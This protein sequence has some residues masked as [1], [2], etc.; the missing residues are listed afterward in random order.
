[1]GCNFAEFSNSVAGLL[2]CEGAPSQPVPGLCSSSSKERQAGSSAEA[3]LCEPSYLLAHCCPVSMSM[4]GNEKLA[5]LLSQHDIAYDDRLSVCKA[6]A[7]VSANAQNASRIAASSELTHSM[8][9][10]L[11][12]ADR[13][14][15]IDTRH[16]AQVCLAITRC[17]AAG[18]DEASLAFSKAPGLVEGLCRLQRDSEPFVRVSAEA[19]L[20]LM[21]RCNEACGLNRRLLRAKWKHVLDVDHKPDRGSQDSPASHH[22]MNGEQCMRGQRVVPSS[23]LIEAEKSKQAIFASPPVLSHEEK[24]TSSRTVEQTRDSAHSTSTIRNG[25]SNSRVQS[26]QKTPH[27]L[28]YQADSIIS[29]GM[30]S[31]LKHG[32]PS[33]SP[34]VPSR[35]SSVVR[36]PVFSPT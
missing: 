31:E 23:T 8:G 10:L 28:L 14:P 22:R 13:N 2:Q 7:D 20:R 35:T 15:D 4:I 29:T 11:N 17:V 30:Q 9:I 1:M 18:G 21:G 3:S 12:N 24:W 33:G 25:Q 34:L 6:L 5:R 27:N 36:Q 16:Q 26:P 32:T 19:A